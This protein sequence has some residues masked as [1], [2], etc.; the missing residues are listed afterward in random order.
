MKRKRNNII[1]DDILPLEQIISD[2]VDNKKPILNVRLTDLSDLD[3]QQHKLLDDAWHS[4]GIE[5][6]RQIMHRLFE[7]AE[8]DVCLNFDAIFKRRLYDEDEEVRCTAIE[9]LWENE[10]SS[11]IE[12]LINLMKEDSSDRIQTAA[13]LALS[14][15]AIS[16]ISTSILSLA[17]VRWFK[18]WRSRK[19]G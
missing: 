9:G 4:I 18:V 15:F 17:V 13:A 8:D 7:L 6:K 19:L 3:L 1:E 16:K 5:R 2:L 11:L 10:E 14:R 12:P